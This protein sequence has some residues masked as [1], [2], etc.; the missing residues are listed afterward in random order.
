MRENVCFLPFPCPVLCPGSG[1]RHAV[2]ERLTRL[3][4]VLTMFVPSAAT[5]RTVYTRRVQHW[6]EEFPTYT[7][8]YLPEFAQVHH[9]PSHHYN[10]K[11]MQLKTRHKFVNCT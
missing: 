11:A 6:L 5:L 10:D 2:S 4:T 7:V 8:D 3:F 1:Q 9:S